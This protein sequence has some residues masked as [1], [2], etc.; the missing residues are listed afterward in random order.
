MVCQTQR[1]VHCLARVAGREADAVGA[2]GDLGGQLR[3]DRGEGVAA[4][5][6]K[7]IGST[8]EQYACG[9]CPNV[10]SMSCRPAVS[11]QVY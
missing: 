4:H 3:V 2:E 9:G 10:S 7:K 1:L 11:L 6:Q 5:L 8:P